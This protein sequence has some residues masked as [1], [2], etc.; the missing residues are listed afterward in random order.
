[1]CP[2]QGS[3]GEIRPFVAKFGLFCGENA[4][5]KQKETRKNRVSVVN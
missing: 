1:M 5:I 3:C 2:K 4:K